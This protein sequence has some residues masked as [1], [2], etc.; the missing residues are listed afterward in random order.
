[1]LS[2]LAIV[3]LTAPVLLVNAASSASEPAE[4]TVEPSATA[5][6]ATAAT[7][8]ALSPVSN[9]K[10]VAF[11]RFYQVWLENTVRELLYWSDLHA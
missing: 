6:A 10:G 9:V 5:V 7:Q 3:L 11:D 1:M 2:N 4:K 8:S